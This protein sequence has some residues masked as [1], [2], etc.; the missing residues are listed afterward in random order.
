[1][2]LRRLIVSALVA[3]MSMPL[4]A[5]NAETADEDDA[6]SLEDTLNLFRENTQRAPQVDRPFDVS[7]PL[8]EAIL[9]FEESKRI[10]QAQ[11]L[12]KNRSAADLR[13]AVAD[14]SAKLDVALGRSSAPVT[15]SSR[16]ATGDLLRVSGQNR[17]ETAARLSLLVN[18]FYLDLTGSG[19]PLVFIATGLNFPDAMAA[20]A[21]QAPILLT[22][23]NSV[24]V[25]T[26]AAL[27]VIDPAFIIVLGGTGAVSTAVE[28][29]LWDNT[30]A[31]VERVSGSSRYE[32]AAQ[33]AQL[34]GSCCGT[35]YLAT[36]D[37]FPDALAAGP[38]AGFEFAS[39]LLARRDTLPTATSS[40]LQWLD[41]DRVVVSGG[42]GAVSETVRVQAGNFATLGSQRRAGSDRYSTAVAVGEPVFDSINTDVVFLTTGL[43]FPDALAAGPA[44]FWFGGPVLLTRPNCLPQVVENRLGVLQ[45]VGT[46][47]VGG[48]GAIADGAVDSTC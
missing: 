41:P 15:Q 22:Q 1:M 34:F 6:A 46:V 33:V 7:L 17:Y 4:A 40:E 37:N 12:S 10:H 43:N 38:P 48:T 44:A 45:P 31:A 2:I 36:G 11:G 39:I 5:A 24:P 14:A 47:L 16:A 27:S 28:D 13:D 25:E 23:P 8:G 42:V 3:A 20:S 19:V 18:D 26:M 21:V 35:T 30:S 32:T 29:F 9:A